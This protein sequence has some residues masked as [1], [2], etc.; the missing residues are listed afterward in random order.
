MVKDDP[1]KLWNIY[2]DKLVNYGLTAPTAQQG[3]IM[4]LKLWFKR[5]YQ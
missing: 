4:P 5:R 1:G 3:Y 2:I